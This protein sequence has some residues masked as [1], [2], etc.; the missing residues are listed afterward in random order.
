[1]GKITDAELLRQAAAL[2]GIRFPT[3]EEAREWL[4]QV[5]EAACRGAITVQVSS[6]PRSTKR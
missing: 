6:G 1:M 2:P 5:K 3:E 4:R